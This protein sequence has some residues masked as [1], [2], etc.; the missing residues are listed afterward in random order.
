MSVL[1]FIKLKQVNFGTKKQMSLTDHGDK[2]IPPL[3]LFM[4]C[5]VVERHLEMAQPT[6]KRKRF[7]VEVAVLV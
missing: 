1:W 2:I 6:K 3:A 4:G 5:G 7:H